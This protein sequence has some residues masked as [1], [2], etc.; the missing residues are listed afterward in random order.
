M[1][2][3]T[4]YGAVYTTSVD[5]S[6]QTYENEELKKNED[7]KKNEESGLPDD[8]RSRR[9]EQTLNLY[10]GYSKSLNSGRYDTFRTGCR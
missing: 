8:V 7:L 2:A 5:H 3:W 4:A 10:A 9:R 6:Y 1:P